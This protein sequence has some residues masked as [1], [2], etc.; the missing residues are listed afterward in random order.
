MISII[1][2]N[3]DSKRISPLKSNI[4]K[5][6]GEVDFEI[7]IINNSNNS[8]S[9]FQAYNQGVTKSKYPYIIFLHDDVKFHTVNFGK[10]LINLSLPKLGVLGIAGSKI[11]T[12]TT[13]P[14]WISNHEKVNDGIVY[15]HNIQ[16]FQNSE[17]KNINVSFEKEG[18]VEEVIIVDGVLLFTT[19]ENCLLNPFD[20]KY[21]SFH[22]YDLDFSLNQVKSGKINYVTNSILLEHYSAGNLNKEWINS[23]FF[24]G[25]KWQ[26]FN[27]VSSIDIDSEKYFEKLAFNS[28]FRVL[29]ENEFFKEAM[30]LFF[31]NLRFL[32][33]SNLKYLYKSF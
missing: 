30:I 18:Q 2:C 31:S 4:N 32:S 5:M 6:I 16:H 24:F 14:W 15:Q 13:S 9:I 19:K 33:F 10:I 27:K 28:R 11:K 26:E 29:L 21:N 17:P 7:I 1:V 20:E 3:K 8:L 12:S 25:K 23:S 22:F